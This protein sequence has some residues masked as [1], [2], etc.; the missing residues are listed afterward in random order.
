W[1]PGNRSCLK[2]RVERVSPP[3]PVPTWRG[4]QEFQIARRGNY[5]SSRPI[6]AWP[7]G[8]LW[9][10]A[11]RFIIST[12]IDRSRSLLWLAGCGEKEHAVL[13]DLI[14]VTTRDGCVLD[15]VLLSATAP[16]KVDVDGVCFVHGTGGN[17][18]SSSM[19][20]TFGQKF[21]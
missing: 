17:F 5:V 2:G 15:G 10:L 6:L 8:R 3:G 13:V 14:R 16:K 12:A 20:D 18:Y 19:L 7:P 1:G 21:L 11:E 9:H 4:N